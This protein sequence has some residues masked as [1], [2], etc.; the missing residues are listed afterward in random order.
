[1]APVP[2]RTIPRYKYGLNIVKGALNKQIIPNPIQKVPTNI[3][4]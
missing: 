2:E 4:K 3:P 1:M